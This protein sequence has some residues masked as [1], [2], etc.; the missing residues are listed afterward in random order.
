MC[1][2]GFNESRPSPVENWRR[3][4][5]EQ[6]TGR[7][8][9]QRKYAKVLLTA[10]VVMVTG[11]APARAQVTHQ[12]HQ[13]ASH[14]FQMLPNGGSIEIQAAD[15]AGVAH[16]RE[17]LA[18]VTAAFSAKEPLAELVDHVRCMPGGATMLAKR[19][20]LT[21]AYRELP[22]GAELRIT[23]ADADALKAVHE[24]ITFQREHSKDPSAAAHAQHAA[25]MSQRGC[26]A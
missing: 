13:A 3:A 23:T 24:F 26:G 25:H 20:T 9:M 5:D 6:Q 2:D 16:V 15:A 10:I 14:Q 11:T 8:K 21:L 19:S 22:R 7:Q 12:Q 4:A 18:E 17:H 1:A